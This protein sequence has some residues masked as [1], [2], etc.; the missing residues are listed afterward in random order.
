[1]V[2]LL[3]GKTQFTFPEFRQRNFLSLYTY[4]LGILELLQPSIFHKEY[5]VLNDILEEYFNMIKVSVHCNFI[6][7]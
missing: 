6:R 7:V 4:V 2:A 5:E 3:K 1:M